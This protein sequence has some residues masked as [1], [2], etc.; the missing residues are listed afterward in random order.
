VSKSPAGAR[1][2]GTLSPEYALLGMLMAGPSHGYELHQRFITDLGHVWHLSESQ[3]YSVLKRLEERGLVSA[4]P[5]KGKPRR[6]QALGITPRGRREFLA[7]LENGVGTNARS[8]RL[9]FLTRL[10]Y[11]NLYEPARAPSVFAQQMAEIESSIG[12]LQELTA[13][14]PAPETYNHLSLDLRLRQMQLI[15]DW[16]AEIGSRL[17]LKRSR[18]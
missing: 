8:I 7:W 10:Y 15:R 13:S 1:H 11:V 17:D 6:R 18:G 5:E 14:V 12:R 3:A 9:E 16:M 4:R 2:A